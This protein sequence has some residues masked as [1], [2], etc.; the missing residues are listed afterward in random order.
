MK[1]VSFFSHLSILGVVYVIFF[2]LG[3]ETKTNTSKVVPTTLKTYSVTTTTMNRITTRLKK[4]TSKV[5]TITQGASTEKTKTI[6]NEN[7]ISSNIV[8]NTLSATVESFAS[9]IF[10]SKILLIVVVPNYL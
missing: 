1:R 10:A 9:S 8:M 5:F 2:S 3:Q 4:Q 7:T 6:I